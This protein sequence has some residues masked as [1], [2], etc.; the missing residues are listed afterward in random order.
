[1]QYRITTEKK[2]EVL[3][4][5]SQE[6]LIEILKKLDKEIKDEELLIVSTSYSPVENAT[7]VVY[8]RHRWLVLE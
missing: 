1:M 4:S 6:T 2:F 7:T 8:E 3:G 5:P